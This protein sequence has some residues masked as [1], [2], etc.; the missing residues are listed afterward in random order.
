MS[1]HSKTNFMTVPKIANAFGPVLLRSQEVT[2]A[3]TNHMKKQC[4][5]VVERMLN[6]YS[7]LFMLEENPQ[8]QFSVKDGASLTLSDLDMF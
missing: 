2:T 3:T 6:H 8:I 1:S 7:A 4:P 5:I